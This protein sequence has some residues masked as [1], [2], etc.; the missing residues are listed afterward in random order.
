MGMSSPL[1]LV[2]AWAPELARR[3]FGFSPAIVGTGH[4]EWTLHQMSAD[5]AIVR[6]AVTDEELSIPRRFIGDVSRLEEPVR[7]VTLL[8]RL[9]YSAG[10]V[11]P[12]NRAV[13]AMPVMPDAPRMRAAVPATV[14]AIREEAEPTP[15][16]KHY[17]RIS[18]A[19]G[20]I[21]CFIAVYVFREGRS[22]RIRR[23]SGR[24]SRLVPHP[25]ES[26]PQAPPQRR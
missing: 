13:I 23:F 19:L 8:R 22:G 17:L 9:E 16:W 12:V 5:E 7:V 2:P 6:N 20:C 10:I 24:P 4:N 25:P 11:R 21:A 18:V 14:V 1:H 3:R 26:V 15:R